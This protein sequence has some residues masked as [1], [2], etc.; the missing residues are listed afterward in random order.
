M[1]TGT[2]NRSGGGEL[3]R[4]SARVERL[5]KLYLEGTPTEIADATV[6]QFCDW[7]WGE[8]QDLTINPEFSW[9][10]RYESAAEMF[11][12]IEQSHLWVSAENYDS[13][14]GINPIYSFMFQ[15][16]HDNDHYQTKSDFSLAGE[17]NAYH[18]TA[19]RTTNLDIQKILYSENVLRSAAALFLGHRPIAKIVFP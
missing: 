12:D 13:S 11:A 5:A 6:A 18:A 1:F 15:A 14:L 17:I 19:R 8:F 16:V 3:G 9:F 4:G 2:K 10:A 7:L